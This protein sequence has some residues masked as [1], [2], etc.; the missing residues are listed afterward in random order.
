MNKE[1][2]AH[3]YVELEKSRMERERVILFLNKT[4][5]FYFA[6]LATGLLGFINKFITP[7]FLNFMV[8]SGLFVLVIG[9]IP[10]VRTMQ[11]EEKKID[12]LLERL[13]NAS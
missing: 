8:I 9:T 12:A 6:Y 7:T 3:I 5:V 1:N 11:K 2:F 4:F 13:K 10:F